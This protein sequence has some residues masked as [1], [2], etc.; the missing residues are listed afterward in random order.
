MHAQIHQSVFSQIKTPA[1]FLHLYQRQAS[2][3]CLGLE[4]RRCAPGR[5]P[6]VSLHAQPWT[7]IPTPP[8]PLTVPPARPARRSRRLLPL[9]R[10]HSSKSP[11]KLIS[12]ADYVERMKAG[13]KHIYYLV[14][15]Q[16]RSCF[17]PCFCP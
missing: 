4:G 8:R 7:P 9:L 3:A 13:Q 12:L 5:W 16:L 17:C 2:L 10:F 1:S 11:D 14:G 15:E 6:P